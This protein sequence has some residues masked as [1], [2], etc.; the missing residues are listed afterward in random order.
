MKNEPIFP[1]RIKIERPG[2]VETRDGNG[3]LIDADFPGLTKREYIASMAMQGILASPWASASKSGF[4]EPPHEG[5]V[6]GLAVIHADALIAEL[7]KK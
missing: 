7:E 4:P 1:V 5:R 3:F 6:A 2:Y